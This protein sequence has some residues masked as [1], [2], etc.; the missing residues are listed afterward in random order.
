MVRT[1]KSKLMQIV[2]EKADIDHLDIPRAGCIII[3]ALA[4]LR[5]I[6]IVPITFGELSQII[7]NSIFQIALKVK[8]NANR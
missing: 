7:L 5:T 8:T 1:Q 3:D 2:E 4:L 6:K